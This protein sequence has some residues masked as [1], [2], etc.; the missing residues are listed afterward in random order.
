[1]TAL[2]EALADPGQ[3]PPIPALPPAA[4]ATGPPEQHGVPRDRVRMLVAGRHGLRHR[5]AADLAS[6]LRPGDVLVV[7]TSDTLPAAL[8]GVTTA[9][10]RVE[11]HLSTLDP[12]AGLGYAT[13]LRRERTRWV[14]EIR[15]AGPL[16]GDP[17]YAG[18]AGDVVRLS[19]GA[20]LEVEAGYPAGTARPR[21]W[22]AALATPEPLM[23]WLSGHGSP[24]RYR[25]VSSPW[26][27]S[28]Y[29][30]P[31]A[32]TPGSVEMPSAGRALTSRIFRRLA[33]RGIEG[34]GIVLHC[35]VSSL[36]PGDPPY[37]EWF[38]VPTAA[39][40]TVAAAKAE[41]RRVIAVGT[42]VVRALESAARATGEVAAGSG[43]TDLVITP[44]TELAAV[45]GLLTGWHEPE[46]S[47]LLMLRAIAGCE[48]LQNSYREAARSGYRWH[49]F[50]DLH[51]ILPT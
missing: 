5:V 18:R 34:A 25:Y 15:M 12:S 16:G 42:T 40:A 26:P 27:L 9:G 46:A 28:A 48:L 45:D 44:G 11:V 31:F 30:T 37:P 23:R 24:I 3:C 33:A 20:V 14:V 43:W 29:R 19:G 2:A 8:P 51:L 41:G 22:T 38:E 36:E 13:A 6:E 47:H 10:E 7:N 49:E 17:S 50:G 32:D 21:L 35:G 39:A 4:I 1:M